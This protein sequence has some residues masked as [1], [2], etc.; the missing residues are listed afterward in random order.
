MCKY[1]YKNLYL[2]FSSHFYVYLSFYYG[3]F[4]KKYFI[5]HTYLI[6]TITNKSNCLKLT[7]QQS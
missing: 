2:F 5:I 4:R 6:A 3:Y 1:L 7:H